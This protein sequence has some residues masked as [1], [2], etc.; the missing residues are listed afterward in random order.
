MGKCTAFYATDLRTFVGKK[1]FT[2]M[3]KDL[4]GKQGSDVKLNQQPVMTI[5]TKKIIKNDFF[6]LDGN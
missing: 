4:S 1:N 6:H 5:G 2:P 3:K